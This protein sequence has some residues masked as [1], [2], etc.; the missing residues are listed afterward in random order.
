MPLASTSTYTHVHI[1][2]QRPNFKT[3]LKEGKQQRPAVLRAL[4]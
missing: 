3:N 2:T 4:L 1:P